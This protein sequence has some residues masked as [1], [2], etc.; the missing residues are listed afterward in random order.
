MT[1]PFWWVLHFFF[2]RCQRHLAASRDAAEVSF[3]CVAWIRRCVKCGRGFV[4]F[5]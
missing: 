1:R 5:D 2:D 3:G 4:E